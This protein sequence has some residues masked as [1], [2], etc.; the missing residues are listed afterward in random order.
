MEV[1][2]NEL[3]PAIGWLGDT[4]QVVLPQHLDL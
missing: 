4:E 3:V 1:Q 2:W